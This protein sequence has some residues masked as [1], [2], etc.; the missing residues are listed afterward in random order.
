[1]KSALLWGL[2]PDEAIP[3]LIVGA[4]ML[5]MLMGRRV[6]GFVVPLLLSLFLAPFVETLMASLPAWLTLLMFAVLGMALLRGA[7]ALFLG[8]RAA[9]HL[10]GALAT[11]VVHLVL[12]GLVAIPVLLVRG[13]I[14]AVRA[15]RNQEVKP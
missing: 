6:L 2:I 5:S 9:G 11:D 8:E 14:L 7:I 1:M 15:I 13:G 4:A 3:L 12:K 10:V